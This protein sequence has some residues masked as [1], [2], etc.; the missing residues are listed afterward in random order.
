MIGYE[1][2]ASIAKEALATDGSV[3][4]L[5]LKKGWL[6]KEALDDI[7]SPQKMCDPRQL[8]R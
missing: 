5:V 4:E 2:S 7:L 6:M 3:Y 1:K 8:P